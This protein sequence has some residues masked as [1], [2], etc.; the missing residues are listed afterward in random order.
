MTPLQICLGFLLA[1]PEVHKIVVGLTSVAE[2]DAIVE[3]AGDPAT[4]W[5]WPS[6]A[7]TNTPLLDPRR[8]PTE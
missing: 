4:G 1:R 7:L 8:W 3:A 2:L 6:F 5:N